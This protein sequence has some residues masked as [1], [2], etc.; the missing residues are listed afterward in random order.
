MVNAKPITFQ[1]SNENRSYVFHPTPCTGFLLRLCSEACYNWGLKQQRRR[2]RGRRLVKNEFILLPSNFAV[3]SSP[4]VLKHFARSF[5]VA[6]FHR[7]V[8]KCTKIY[9]ARAQLLLSLLNLL[10]GDVLVAVA[11]AVV[12]VVCLL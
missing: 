1:H 11:V 6:V 9:D 10:F 2:R 5:H 7:T 8:Q 4:V 12:V 3:V